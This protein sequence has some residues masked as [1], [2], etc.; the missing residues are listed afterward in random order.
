MELEEKV[1]SRRKAEYDRMRAER[2]ERLGQILKARKEERDLKR[3]M[4]FYLKTEKE[5]LDKLR[6]EEEARKRE[7]Y[8]FTFSFSFC[9]LYALLLWT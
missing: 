5:R 4:L 6:E 7:G 3:K 8:F 2:E 9:K 1:V